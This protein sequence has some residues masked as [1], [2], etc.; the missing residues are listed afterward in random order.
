VRLGSAGAA[1]LVGDPTQDEPHY[2]LRPQPTK[3][4]VSAPAASM[5][6]LPSG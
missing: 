4:S 3:A 2:G 1:L 5:S 6:A